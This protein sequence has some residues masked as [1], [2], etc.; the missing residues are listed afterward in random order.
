MEVDLH[1]NAAVRKLDVVVERAREL[2]LFEQTRGMGRSLEFVRR[3][4]RHIE[5]LWFLRKEATMTGK[6]NKKTN[7]D[8]G[9]LVLAANDLLEEADCVLEMVDLLLLRVLAE[10]ALALTEGHHGSER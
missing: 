10:G 7:L 3:Q 6:K 5:I 9:I 8:V 4:E 2:L 1:A